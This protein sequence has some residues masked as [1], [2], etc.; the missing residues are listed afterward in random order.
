MYVAAESNTLNNKQFATEGTFRNLGLRWGYGL[1]SYEPG[2]TGLTD[3]NATLNFFWLTGR[4][5]NKGYIPIKGSFSLGYL[6][7]IHATFKPLLSNYY[8]T[9]IEAPA[10]QPNI[11]TKALFMEQYR[12][13]QY[14]AGGI[15][16]LYSFSEQLYA[17]AEAYLFFPVQQIL[18]DVNNNAYK[19]TY[20]NNMKTIFS[21]SLN[22]I[23]VAGPVSFHVGYITE[24]ENPWV[25]QL[26]FGYLLFNK[27]STTL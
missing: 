25:I 17:K 13:Y 11:I 5:E 2:S 27:K 14:V 24:E 23:S 4:Y 1:E 9:I 8:S 3:V 21:T 15:M 6:A 12:A 20:F 18:R 10:F 19:G 26:S 16:P 22:W 7:V